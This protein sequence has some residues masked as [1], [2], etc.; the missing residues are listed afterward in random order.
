MTSKARRIILKRIVLFRVVFYASCVVILFSVVRFS[1]NYNYARNVTPVFFLKNKSE[2]NF[3]YNVAGVV[4]PGSIKLIRG[5]DELQFVITDYEHE[6]TIFY[7]GST[8]ANFME[9]NTLIAVGNISDPDRPTLFVATKLM[10]DHSY[11]ADKW[12]NRKVEKSIIESGKA[13]NGSFDKYA[14]L[15]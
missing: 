15:V 10:V 6:L 8:P 1:N 2:E 4:K 7:K 14:K 11:N 12:M 13:A 9:G 3:F 5:T